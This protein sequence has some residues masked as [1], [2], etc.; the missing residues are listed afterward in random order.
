VRAAGHATRTVLTL[1]PDATAAIKVT[2]TKP[3]AKQL[4]RRHRL[5]VALVLTGTRDGAGTTTTKKTVV[6]KTKR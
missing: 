4:K 3:A 5:K 6:L 1:E 2:L